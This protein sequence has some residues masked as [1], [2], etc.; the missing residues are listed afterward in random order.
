VVGD[1]NGDGK[2]DLVVTTL[3]STGTWGPYGYY[4]GVSEGNVN[5]LLG[6]GDGTFAPANVYWADSQGLEPVELADVDGDGAVDIVVASYHTGNVNVLHGNGD[7][8]FNPPEAM[9]IGTY[10]GGPADILVADLNGDAQPDV[11]TANYG[12]NTVSVF[13]N[14]YVAPPL[15]PSLSIGDTT[16]TEGNA[17][18]VSAAF[19]VSLSRASDQTVTVQYATTADGLAV[20]GR[21]FDSLVGTLTFLPGETSKEILVA[22]RGDLTDEYDETFSVAL[23]SPA[24]AQVADG[25]GT[26]TILD[27]D[28][29][30]T[31]VIS[32]VS[33]REGRKGSTAFDFTVSLSTASEKDVSVSFATADGTATAAGRD[34]IAQSG[35]LFFAAGQ[36][37]QILRISVVGDRSREASETFFVNLDAADGA[38][39]ADGQGAGTI[40][41]DDVRGN[42]K[43]NK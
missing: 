7:G 28:A 36:T 6:N 41:D 21:D 32:D 24:N 39:I 34:Y 14:G 43:K 19:T 22:V 5:V 8:T 26:G 12:S 15:P 30:P 18:I 38:M 40:L 33:K 27:D 9:H 23:S 16:V 11:A 1:V 3:V 2:L 29:A 10:N 4:Y 35:T 13:L 17:G 31:I 25:Q 37:G 42:S 20:A